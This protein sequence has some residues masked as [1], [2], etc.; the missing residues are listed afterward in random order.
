MH[1][2]KF[3]PLASEVEM[4]EQGI[5]FQEDDLPDVPNFAVLLPGAMLGY[6]FH[7]KKWSE[8]YV[9][10]ATTFI[11]DLT[12][13][14]SM[15]HVEDVPWN[16]NA[17]T[18][19]VLK[20][21]KKDTIK[22]LVAVHLTTAQNMDVV[23]NKG[24]GL[25]ILLHGSPGTGMYERQ[26]RRFIANSLEGKTLTAESVAEI[27]Q[28]PLYRVTCGDIG[29]D[30]ESVEKYMESVLLI[31][32]IWGCVVLLDEADVFL[33]E[34]Q[35]TDLARNALVSVFLRVLEYYD[36]IL[37]LTT[38]RVGTFDEAFKSR[39]QLAIHYPPLDRPGRHK[40]WLNFLRILEDR[41]VDMASEDLYDAAMSLADKPFNGRQIRNLLW[42]AAQV[43]KFEN[44]TLNSGH[45]ETVVRISE[46]FETYLHQTHGQTSEEQASRTGIRAPEP[47]EEKKKGYNY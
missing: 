20:K 46:E 47:V 43:A 33:E 45:L 24:N 18:R 21:E 13:S 8:F 17:F 7:D 23:E 42:T 32:T 11:D 6:A 39:I 40:I 36:G 15:D 31:G 19:L 14:L 37:I 26:A 38:N 27:A 28:K 22:A 30:A 16:Y 5:Y 9:E 25:I 12:G 34:R 2:T 41:K 4:E 3:P 35:V 44:T 1:P 29:T 10:V